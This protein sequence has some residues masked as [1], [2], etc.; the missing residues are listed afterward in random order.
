MKQK[1]ME[2]LH[3]LQLGLGWQ[4]RGCLVTASGSWGLRRKGGSPP[5]EW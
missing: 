2:V 4:C 3:V 1:R 5:A